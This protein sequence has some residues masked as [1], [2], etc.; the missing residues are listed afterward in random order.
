MPQA[1]VSRASHS[2]FA[3]LFDILGGKSS[4]LA[5]SVELNSC[6]RQLIQAVKMLLTLRARLVFPSTFNLPDM[7]AVIGF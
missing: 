5:L 6:F 1:A 4:V 2:G 3:Q 7:K